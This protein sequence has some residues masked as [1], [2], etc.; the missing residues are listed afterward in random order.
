MKLT[1]R[2]I[3]GLD[4]ELVASST[5]DPAS[6]LM[7]M[8]ARFNGAEPEAL[9]DD[10]QIT[11]GLLP[12]IPRAMLRRQFGKWLPKGAD[13]IVAATN[14]YL[15][16]HAAERGYPLDASDLIASTV[17]NVQRIADLEKWKAEQ[18]MIRRAQRHYL[19]SET[20]KQ[21]VDGKRVWVDATVYELPPLMQSEG[22]SLK[23]EDARY[24]IR[25]PDGRYFD[26]GQTQDGFKPIMSDGPDIALQRIAKRAGLTLRGGAHSIVQV[27]T[28]LTGVIPA[29]TT[30][31][32]RHQW[33]V[34]VGWQRDPKTTLSSYYKGDNELSKAGDPDDRLT[35]SELDYQLLKGAAEGEIEDFQGDVVD[36]MNDDEELVMQGFMRDE[37]D[38]PE[39][40]NSF[41]LVQA[42]ANMGLQVELRNGSAI[43]NHPE[44]RGQLAVML[45]ESHS[46]RHQLTGSIRRVKSFIDDIM[47]RIFHG[48]PSPLEK[49][50]LKTELKAHYKHMGR[51]KNRRTALLENFRDQLEDLEAQ[52]E[53]IETR[54]WTN[55]RYVHSGAP[56]TVSFE[57]TH[58]EA[59]N[60]TGFASMRGTESH[61]PLMEPV[62]TEPFMAL[63]PANSVQLRNV[64][65]ETETMP[66]HRAIRGMR[67]KRGTIAVTGFDLGLGLPVKKVIPKL[68]Q[69]PLTARNASPTL[70]ARLRTMIRE[71]LESG[72]LEQEV[73]DTFAIAL[74]QALRG[75]LR[76]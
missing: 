38:E 59:A 22:K 42:A 49:E 46:E 19:K 72:T 21:L 24:A 10:L 32:H 66:D 5:L 13:A 54:T 41:L 28:G 4:P 64:V 26:L 65:V 52:S 29:Y 50:K 11:H 37:T 62:R 43:W 3:T 76:A 40:M 27:L 56:F 25:L 44:L 33:L 63:S 57:D 53:L 9:F 48:N 55:I 39:P 1:L 15:T 30:V 2:T 18:T 61:P 69:A 34:I 68:P 74:E 12:R 17:F 20:S 70:K 6:I 60:C 71:E 45:R 31:W 36:Y 51:L 73:A 16:T 47:A 67:V 75:A 23:H 7:E 58:P 14:E 8:E 35:L